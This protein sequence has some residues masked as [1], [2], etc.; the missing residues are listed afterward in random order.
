[1]L[2]YITH[3]YIGVMDS[4]GTCQTS[5]VEGPL[6]LLQNSGHLNPA[7]PGPFGHQQA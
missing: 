7:L 3:L 4:G 5:P 2:T 6:T 1:M